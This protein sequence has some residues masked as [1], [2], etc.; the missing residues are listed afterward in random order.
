MSSKLKLKSDK[1]AMIPTRATAIKFHGNLH[2]R[3]KHVL[4]MS[5]ETFCWNAACLFSNGT[6]TAV[7]TTTRDHD[8][9][10]NKTKLNV[11]I[12]LKN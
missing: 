12:R 3:K 1:I 9:M 7:Q 11:I 8:K 10:T 2:N 5:W 6:N 4:K